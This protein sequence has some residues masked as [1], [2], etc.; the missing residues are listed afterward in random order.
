MNGRTPSPPAA[1]SPAFARL[2]AHFVN[3]LIWR[4]F[5]PTSRDS[6]RLSRFKAAWAAAGAGGGDEQAD[7]VA[8]DTAGGEGAPRLRRRPV[9]PGARRHAP[10]VALPL[11]A[12]R[13]GALDGPGRRG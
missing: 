12:Q 3:I 11:Q 2:R 7:A 4:C 1:L 6:S 5:S 13:A 8:K 10:V 9:A